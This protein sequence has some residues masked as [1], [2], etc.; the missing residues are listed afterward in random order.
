M[1]LF[2]KL[3]CSLLL[4]CLPALAQ[5]ALKL[6]TTTEDLAALARA[7]GG[8]RV[9][10]ISLT[11]GTRDAHFNEP[12]P[13]LIR[14][15]HKADLLL[16]IGAEL[17]IGWLPPVLQGARNARVQPGA[18]GYLDLSATVGPLL[19]IPSGPVSRAAGHIH[20]Q[21]NPHYWL[22]PQRG[23]RMAQAI[24]A[25]LSELDGAHA[26]GYQRNLARFE[27]ELQARLTGWQEAFKPLKDKPVL[28]YHRS[29]LYLAEAFDFRTAGE[30]E[31]K[32]GISPSAAHLTQLVDRIKA[33]GIGL[34]IL[35]PYYERRSAAF[36][37]EQTG[38]RVAVVPP[39]VGARP[40]I[41]NYFDLFDAIVAALREA[42]A[43]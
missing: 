6:V 9:E 42:G 10:V 34:L 33:E 21:G 36:L 31:P 25:R 1:T 24:A 32:P 5:A 41:K 28:S 35:E 4:L 8:E 40:E 43:L 23:L 20:A 3:C 19:D 26:A 37:A 16:V 18:P 22:N 39:S 38:I 13:S 14:Q 11:P 30:I 7:V 12:R 2:R 27:Q 15:L 29:W 17:E